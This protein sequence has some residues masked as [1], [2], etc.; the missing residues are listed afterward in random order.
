[1]P[2]R[3]SSGGIKKTATTNIVHSP[4]PIA[5]EAT[6]KHFLVHYLSRIKSL[7]PASLA[8]VGVV[9]MAVFISWHFLSINPD[10][11]VPFAANAK[12]TSDEI[13]PLVKQVSRHF[14]VPEG[15]EPVVATVLNAT[16]LAK[17]QSFF[18][19]ANNGDKLLIFGKTGQAV[20][21][22]PSRDIIVNVG[23]VQSPLEKGASAR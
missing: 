10:A 4:I 12:T 3:R 19:R 17:E 22:S 11:A 5:K 7:T 16:A 15:D 23:P 14:A 21:Y 6:P 8:V 1:M 20:L 9:G 13:A 2:T 18:Q